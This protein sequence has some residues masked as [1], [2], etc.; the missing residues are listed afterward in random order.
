MFDFL[1]E[2]GVQ[3]VLW[4]LMKQLMKNRKLKNKS[5]IQLTT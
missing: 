5:K 3:A 4:P 1:L 2:N